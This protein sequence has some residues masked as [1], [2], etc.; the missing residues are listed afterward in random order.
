[1]KRNRNL[2]KDLLFCI[3][4][5]SLLGTGSVLLVQSGLGSDALSTFMSGMLIQFGIS[6]A[7]TNLYINFVMFLL[8][9][10]LEKQQLGIGSIL[11]PLATSAAISIGFT[12]IPSL[13]SFI[14]YLSVISGILLMAFGI[15]VASITSIGKNPIDAFCFALS[16]KLKVKYNYVRSPLDALFMISGIL[17]HATFG[18]GTLL[19]VIMVG[20]LVVYFMKKMEKLPIK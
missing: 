11:F 8:T 15:A 6:M 18:I 4:G 17:M 14:S 16:N 9:I 19:A 7:Q 20:T 5:G 1:M 3:L 13:N 2:F 10:F 12:L